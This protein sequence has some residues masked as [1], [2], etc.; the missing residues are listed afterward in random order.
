MTGQVKMKI[1]QSAQKEQTQNVRQNTNKKKSPT[2][3]AAEILTKLR[4]I[5]GGPRPVAVLIFAVKKPQT[6]AS[7]EASTKKSRAYTYVPVMP[8]AG[9]S[10]SSALS[11]VR[12]KLSAKGWTYVGSV[13]N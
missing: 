1:A 13:S 8:R 5:A 2:E 12:S 11:R 3:K 4:N 10:R 7:T 9:E 6:G